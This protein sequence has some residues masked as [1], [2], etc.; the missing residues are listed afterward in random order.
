MLLKG[1]ALP[2][3]GCVRSPRGGGRISRSPNE[4]RAALHATRMARNLTL[5]GQVDGCIVACFHGT[6]NQTC[7]HTAIVQA[8]ATSATFHPKHFWAGSRGAARMTLAHTKPV[9]A[10]GGCT[11]RLAQ[12][13]SRRNVKR[14]KNTGLV[15]SFTLRI[16]P[17]HS[18]HS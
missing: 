13:R 17:L 15:I 6:V 18:G 8:C 7:T 1:R 4:K 10:K 2:P 5:R 3:I 14:A 11:C 16:T 9:F 12:Q